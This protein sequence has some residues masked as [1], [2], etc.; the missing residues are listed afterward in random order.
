MPLSTFRGG[1]WQPIKRLLINHL[2][3]ERSVKRLLTFQGGQWRTV[4]SVNA[5]LQ[6]DDIGDPAMGYAGRT[7]TA[8]TSRV[9]VTVTGG[10]GPF[11]YAWTLLS[12]TSGFMPTAISP[13]F[14]STA[15]RQTGLVPGDYHTAEFQ[16]LVTDALGATGTCTTTAIFEGPIEAGGE[17]QP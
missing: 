10:T 14:A 12:H 6:V 1:V 8:T 13:S 2:G 4:F 17:V 15:F 9:Q 16:C 3:T 5:P 7:S 11:T